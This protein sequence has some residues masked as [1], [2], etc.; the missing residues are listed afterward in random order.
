MEKLENYQ[1]GFDDILLKQNALSIIPPIIKKAK[2]FCCDRTWPRIAL[3]LKTLI[4]NDKPSLKNECYIGLPDDL[5][6]LRSLVWK[7]NL[8]YLP[9]NVNKWE[10][11]LQKKRNEYIDIKNGFKLRQKVEIEI[12]QEIEST[13]N[14]NSI[15]QEEKNNLFLL[16]QNTDR[17]LLETI[18]KDVN[19]THTNFDFFSK[20]IKKNDTV[21]QE[22]I[23]QM[24]IRKRNC[25]YQDFKTVYT[26]GRDSLSNI[27]FETHADVLGRILYIYSK[28]NKDVNYVQ[29]MNEILA[30]I[31]YCYVIGE[32]GESSDSIEADAFWSFSILMDGIKEMFIK[33]KDND[34]GG[35]FNKIEIFEKL[36]EKLDKSLYKHFKKLD[37]KMTHF[38]FRWFNLFFGQ[39]FIIPDILRLWDTIFSEQ[40]KFYFTYFFSIAILEMKRKELLQ[41]DF[42]GT[43]KLLQKIDDEDIEVIISKAINIKKENEKKCKHI[44]YEKEKKKEDSK[45]KETGQN[46]NKKKSEFFKFI[47]IKKE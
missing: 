5:P 33:E 45:A 34:K 40:D 6:C 27:P 46:D 32:T 43:I 47:F 26:K 36:I 20:P 38:S 8:R 4:E 14:R 44:I 29:G 13:K 41:S 12:F 42:F 35:I 16:S 21:T 11:S 9:Y 30:P 37:V 31:Y 23:D 2:T 10:S 18:D 24:L 3:I 1:K 25:T 19:R 7:I 15:T 17:D 28:L 22:E 39:D